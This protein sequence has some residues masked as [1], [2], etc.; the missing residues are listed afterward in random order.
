MP[1]QAYVP[2]FPVYCTRVMAIFETGILADR[3]VNWMASPGM[4]EPAYRPAD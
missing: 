3:R 1:S 4:H 2:G